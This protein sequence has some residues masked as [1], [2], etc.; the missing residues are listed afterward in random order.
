MPHV[1]PGI[2]QRELSELPIF[3][4][5]SAVLLPHGVLPL[6][7]FEPRYREMTRD[8]LERGLP[9]AI[10]RIRKGEFDAQGRPVVEPIIGV[11]RIIQNEALEDGRYNIL[12]F[13]M[14]RA[15]ISEELSVD[16][17]YRQV[18]AE[19]LTADE[20]K[21]DAVSQLLRLIREVV[22]TLRSSKPAISSVLLRLL[23]EKGS[24]SAVA[25]RMCGAIIM[26]GAERQ[27]VLEELNVEKRLEYLLSK[28]SELVALA[29]TPSDDEGGPRL[30]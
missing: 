8:A 23:D 7:I 12:L 16:T 9:I 29:N 4:L 18:R 2:T 3:P 5:E 25:D 17:A 21:R 30:N 1:A 19:L 20:G 14:E 13:G 10:A 11:G 6:H 22:F 28:V 24:A 15:R 26:D 27:Q